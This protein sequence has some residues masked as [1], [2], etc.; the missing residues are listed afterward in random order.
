MRWVWRLGIGLAIAALLA[1]LP[2]AVLAGEGHNGTEQAFTRLIVNQTL[3]TGNSPAG[4][5]FT[6]GTPNHYALS[7]AAAYGWGLKNP[8]D[9]PAARAKVIAFLQQQLRTYMAVRAADEFETS[10]HF[11]WWQAAYGSIWLNAS[12]AG[13]AEILGL[14]RRVLIQQRTVQLACSTPSGH[15]VIPGARAFLG[16]GESDQRMQRDQGR[17]IIDGR[18]VRLPG[19]VIDPRKAPDSTDRVGLWLLLQVPDGEKQLVRS[20]APEMPSIMNALQIQRGAGGLVAWFDRF[21]GTRPAYFAWV[22]FVTGEERYGVRPEWP[23][24]FLG[25]DRPS[26]MVVPA[27]PGGAA[28]KVYRLGLTAPAAN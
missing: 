9:L 14:I 12:R 28:L 2:L 20:A 1:A 23:K 27:L 22:N 3:G 11:S 24:G 26:D 8:A 13:D 25:G 6:G 17:A 7:V 19:E 10:S 21:T 18:R 5:N 15:I 16:A 4:M